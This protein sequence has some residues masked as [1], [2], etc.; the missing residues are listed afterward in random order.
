MMSQCKVLIAFTFALLSQST[1]YLRPCADASTRYI[2][3]IP[4]AY[5]TVCLSASEHGERIALVN[6]ISGVQ[7]VAPRCSRMASGDFSSLIIR[8][9]PRNS[10]VS[11]WLMA[12]EPTFAV[13]HVVSPNSRA[14][15]RRGKTPFVSDLQANFDTSYELRRQGRLYR[16]TAEPTKEP[17]MPSDTVPPRTPCSQAFDIYERAEMNQAEIYG[18]AS[19]RSQ[20]CL[21]GTSAWCIWIPSTHFSIKAQQLSRK[22]YMLW[23]SLKL[24]VTKLAACLCLLMSFSN[25]SRKQLL[26]GTSSD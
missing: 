8:Q 23:M 18:A 10:D 9:A 15:R 19:S 4:M 5:T 3:Q 1:L 24:Q 11:G 6:W 17:K 7:W 12:G 21:L 20:K 2:R 25:L 26:P 13:G 16:D 14:R 22:S